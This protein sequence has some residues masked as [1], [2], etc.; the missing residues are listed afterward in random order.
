MEPKS[1]R[2]TKGNFFSVSCRLKYIPEKPN[3]SGAATIYS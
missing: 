2:Y 3:E 1:E